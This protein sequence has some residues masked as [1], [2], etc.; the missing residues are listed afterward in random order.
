MRKLVLLVSTLAV[1]CGGGGGGDSSS[2][3]S[4][5][6]GG[7]SFS[8]VEV[9]AIPAGTGS[10]SCT[11][12]LGGQTASVGVKAIALQISSYA[13]ACSDFASSTCQFHVSAQSVTILVAK[14]NPLGT[15]P[16]LPPGTYTLYSSPSTTVPDGSG[17]LNVGYAA[18]LGTD[19][20][21]LGTPSVPSSGTVRLDSVGNP[22]TGHVSVRFQDGSTL[23]GDFSAPVCAG[24][25]PDICQLAQSGA[26]CTG[27]TCMP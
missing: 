16:A 25:S 24:L 15:E 19:A 6:V 21:C 17:M 11:V 27:A 12:S 9:R 7:R 23:E 4:G 14:V 5:T 2:G 10:T 18:A 1:A 8:P 22:V 3:L 20:T 26:I 13:G